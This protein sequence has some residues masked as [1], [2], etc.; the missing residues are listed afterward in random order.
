MLLRRCPWKI[1]ISEDYKDSV[2]LE[3][4]IQLAKEKDV[5]IEYCHLNNYKCCGIIKNLADV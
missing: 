5:D 4:L 1:L 2:E 3:H